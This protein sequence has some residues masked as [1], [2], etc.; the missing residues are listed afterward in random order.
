MPRR[1]LF[2]V[3]LACA[4]V[5]STVAPTHAQGTFGRLQLVISDQDGKPVEGV[6]AT[7]TCEELPDFLEQK[8]TSKKGKVTL[9]FGDG[10]KVYNIKL[11]YPGSAAMD[12]PFKP[13][14]RKT[15]TQEITI[16]LSGAAPQVAAEA[17]E[18]GAEL[19]LTPTERTFNAGVELLQAEDYVGA[20][21]KFLEAVNNK[22]GMAVAHSALAGVYLQLGDL[23]A[24]IAAANRLLELEPQNPL[25]FR[26]LYEAHRQL[27]NEAESK[28]AL[29]A[30]KNLD[31]AG[32]AARIVYNEGVEALKI[33]DRKNARARFEQALE[34]NPELTPAMSALAIVL[35]ND[36]EFASSAELAERILELEPDNA[37]AMTI[38]F[39]AYKS[40]GDEDNERA[41][42]A[43]ILASGSKDIGKL[44]YESGVEQFNSGNL[45]GALK[46]FQQALEADD[47]LSRVHYHLGL[48]LV[49]KGDVTG[50]KEHFRKF[51]E[52]A[53]QDA[54]AP[55]ASE[56][57]KALG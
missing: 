55:A 54:E 46:N 41:S 43:R 20:R 29:G 57:L 56:M 19:S 17:P 22:P 21:D 15:V 5:I 18:S 28:Q 14:I 38:A 7:A 23:E 36:G 25:A 44:L 10:T 8:V 11:E 2:T 45:D 9:A 35:I 4:L 40:L 27:G 32:D 47:S 42:F 16:D 53:P 30:L 3:L 50:A 49:N 12:M 24:A 51:L 26:V 48:C 6:T 13:E 33:G 37:R 39:D 34:I 1:S 31:T 52:M